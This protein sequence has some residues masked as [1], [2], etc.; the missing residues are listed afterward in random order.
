MIRLEVLVAKCPEC[1]GLLD[2]EVDEVEEGEIISCPD[3]GTELEVVNLHP[4][5][6]DALEEEEE[7]E[8]K[9]EEEKSERDE[10]ENGLEDDER[11]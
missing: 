9:E 6:L 2:L 7:E 5:E 8:E 1:G 3:C 10:W 11:I 4:L